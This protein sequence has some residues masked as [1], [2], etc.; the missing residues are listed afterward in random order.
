[1]T[2]TVNRLQFGYPQKTIF[3]EIS[4]SLPRGK[5]VGIVGPNGGGKSTL[6]KL[7]AGQEQPRSGEILLKGKPLSSYGMKA[8]A[9]ELAYLPQRPLVPPG[10]RVEQLVQYGRHPHQGWFNQWSDEDARMVRWAR[11]RMQLDAIWHQSASSLSGGQAQRVW[12]AMVLAQDAD[13]ILLDEPTSALDIGHQTEV[14]EAIHR[15]AAEGKTVLIVIHDLAT[16]ARYCDE[17]IALGDGGIQA[18]GPAREVVTKPLIDRLYQTDVDI[19]HAPGD[20]AP[21]IVPRRR[22]GQ[23]VHL[24]HTGADRQRA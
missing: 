8:L 2:L 16:A 19:L 3:K 18:M 4:F 20:G 14:M 13:I 5:L 17:L 11:E 15:V 6:L 22:H 7:L 23:E 21:V 24:A 12:L 10:I 1:M 9:R